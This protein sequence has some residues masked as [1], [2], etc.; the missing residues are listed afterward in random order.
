MIKLLFKYKWYIII[1]FFLIIIEPSINSILN[2][3]L[4]RMFNAANP[5]AEIIKLIRLLTI[6]FLLWMLKRVVAY[7]STLLKARYICNA[8][9]DV[10]HNVFNSL[11]NFD[12]ANISTI[13][14]SGEYI[15]LFTNDIN[16]LETRFLNQVISLISNVFSIAIL[17]ASFFALNAKLAI[18]IIAFG[19]ISM[20]VPL[21]FSK[22]L[23]EKNLAYSR[24]ISTFTQRLKEYLVA[25]P[26]IKNYSIENA[27]IKK[28]EEINVDS[29]DAKFESDYIL[30]LANNVG[31]LLAWFMQFIGVGL[32]LALVVNGEIAIG[33]VVAAQS[34]ASDLALPLQN[35]I[36][37]INSIRSVKE[38][39]KKFNSYA[40]G[41]E[42]M[43]VL[44]ENN[45]Q[46]MGVAH[47]A[48]MNE[49]GYEIEFKDLKLTIEDKTI[50][51]N[52]SFKFEKGKKYLMVGLNGSGK[53]SLFRA[54]KRWFGKFYGKITINGVE[55]TS[56]NNEQLSQAV[57]YMNENVSLFSGT[58]RDN[59]SL[60]RT[61]SSDDFDKAIKSAQ[62]QL[63]LNREI[64]DE[65]RNIS[66]GEQ[67]RIE[68]ARSL[69][70]SAGVLIF[71]EVVSTLDIETAYE[72]ERTALEFKDK[73]IIFISHNFSGKLIKEY[74]EI[75]VMEG[76]TLIA[77]GSYEKLINECEYFQRICEIKFGNKI[78]R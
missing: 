77:H 30:N 71:D 53:S 44:Q 54:L 70:E 16:L 59:I 55:V 43:S 37:N 20:F 64:G 69:L 42:P 17:G 74:D 24:I 22:S 18:A 66:S 4:Q 56:L 32:G 15:S 14:S 19:V 72:I 10:K 13:A 38:I 41:E 46:G 29:E 57:S 58:I 7:T 21:I 36:I 9:Q 3:W 52:F 45:K 48:R 31:Q 8:K 39:V 2:F 12:I 27:I 23:N 50:I 76:G 47:V 5:G 40:M 25:Y 73:T 49:G 34:F 65:G 1:I 11:L 78:M 61:Y 33:T 75:L 28:F 60:F 35:I 68:I 62:M 6:G 26:T 51:D 67:R 63:D